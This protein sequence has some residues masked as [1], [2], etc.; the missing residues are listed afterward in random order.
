[1]VYIILYC[2][3]I[4]FSCYKIIILIILKLIKVPLRVYI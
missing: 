4:I 2:V 3:I 1:M